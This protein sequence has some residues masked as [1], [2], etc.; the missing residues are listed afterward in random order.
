MLLRE[1]VR[2]VEGLVGL[3]EPLIGKPPYRLDLLRSEALLHWLQQKSA[4]SLEER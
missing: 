1:M 3:A 2:R 4:P